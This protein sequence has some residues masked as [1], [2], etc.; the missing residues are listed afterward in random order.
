MLYEVRDIV[1][2]V[3]NVYYKLK[4]NVISNIK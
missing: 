4:I 3:I 2:H 1:L